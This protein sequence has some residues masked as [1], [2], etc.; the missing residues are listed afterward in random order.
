MTV[1]CPDAVSGHICPCTHTMH[2]YTSDCLPESTSVSSEANDCRCQISKAAIAAAGHVFVAE[3]IHIRSV[4]MN[5]VTLQTAGHV[6]R[7][8]GLRSAPNR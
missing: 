8:S 1:P 3:V 6:I 5:A 4:K 2:A 7:R